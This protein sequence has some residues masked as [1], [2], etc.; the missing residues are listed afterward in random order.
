[1][2]E[3]REFFLEF[4]AEAE[5]YDGEAGVV[6]CGCLVFLGEDFRCCA[7][8]GVRADGAVDVGDASV[9]DELS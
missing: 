8:K 6:V 5:G 4:I 3:V 2:F 1:L 7:E 9:P